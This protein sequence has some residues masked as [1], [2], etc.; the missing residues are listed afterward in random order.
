MWGI[1]QVYLLSGNP[2]SKVD[3]AKAM[4]KNMN[5]KNMWI[6]IPMESSCAIE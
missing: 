4:K 1:H 6:N 3:S 2:T 5:M